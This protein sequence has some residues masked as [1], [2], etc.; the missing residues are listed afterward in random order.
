MNQKFSNKY[1]STYKY[2][3]FHLTPA[4]LNGLL[5]NGKNYIPVVYILNGDLQQYDKYFSDP[6]VQTNANAELFPLY[7]DVDFTYTN[8]SLESPNPLQGII[9]GDTLVVSQ[10]IMEGVGIINVDLVNKYIDIGAGVTRT[11]IPNY[12]YFEDGNA[13]G[14]I[15]QVDIDNTNNSTARI[16]LLVDAWDIEP[17]SYN[18]VT[19]IY[20]TSITD[21][22]GNKAFEY[23]N[24]KDVYIICF[25]N[26]Y[27]PGY[28]KAR[29][30]LFEDL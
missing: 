28:F 8:T 10:D 4:E 13:K 29:V 5:A 1:Q 15:V 14:T 18:N 21:T 6:N 25:Y 26:M 30:D 11:D 20:D 2:I 17:K 7:S 3:D 24:T 22:I 16:Y 23:D 9:S 27:E 19:Y 12:I